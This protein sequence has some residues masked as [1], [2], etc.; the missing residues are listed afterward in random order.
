[1]PSTH[2]ESKSYG[3]SDLSRLFFVGCDAQ[4][5]GNLRKGVGLADLDLDSL[6]ATACFKPLL[7]LCRR[8][9]VRPLTRFGGT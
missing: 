1:M 8:E 2:R 3:G 9:V 5:T 7:D 6:L 4:Q